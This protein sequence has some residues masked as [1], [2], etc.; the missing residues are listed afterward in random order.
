M[1]EADLRV[2]LAEQTSRPLTQVDVVTLDCGHHAAVEAI[3]RAVDEC[4]SGTVVLFDT[5]T[6]A[7]LEL[8]GRLLYETQRR[9]QKPLFVVGSSGIEY[10]LTRYWHTAGT[11]SRQQQQENT[12]KWQMPKPTCPP[13]DCVVVVSGSCSPVTDRQIAWALAQGWAELPLDTVRLFDAGQVEAEIAE[14]TAQIAGQLAAGRSVIVHTCRGPNDARIAATRSECHRRGETTDQLGRVLGT[15]LRKVRLQRR[16]PRIGV[17]GGDTAGQVA[18][19]LGIDALELVAPLAPGAPL[20]RAG[21]R[22]PTIDG[23]QV[24]FKGGQVG[25]DDFFGK[26]LHG[27]AT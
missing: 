16:L 9:E 25:H 7:H 26:L 21:S 3:D 24:A 5:L 11:Q 18:R 15:I 4:G 27:T 22:D 23:I 10:A 19:A 12:P 2:H 20:C 13:I 14:A 1:T 8:I 6:D 17:A